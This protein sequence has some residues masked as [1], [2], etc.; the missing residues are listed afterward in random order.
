MSTMN[1]IVQ[2]LKY[3]STLFGQMP[4]FYTLW[5]LELLT[6]VS[7]ICTLCRNF[8]YSNLGK[9]VWKAINLLAFLCYVALLYSINIRKNAKFSKCQAT[10]VREKYKFYS[11][12]IS[13][14]I[15]AQINNKKWNS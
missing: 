13:W 11:K 15:K 4:N 12:Y 2:T 7:A 5:C 8:Y 1:Y 10:F 14:S 9:F 6:F 3:A